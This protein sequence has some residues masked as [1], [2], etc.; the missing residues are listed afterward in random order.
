V[1]HLAGEER[2]LQRIEFPCHIILTMEVR[3]IEDLRKDFLRQN[4]LNQHF[5][6]V[7]GGDARVDRVLCVLEEA[8]RVLA[9]VIT[10][11]RPPRSCRAAR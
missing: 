4:V 9:E 6:H 2:V 11:A 5:A 8:Q 7:G 10:R 3:I 1:L